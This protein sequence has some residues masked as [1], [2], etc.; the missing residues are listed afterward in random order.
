[1]AVTI[2][3]V[4]LLALV[5]YLDKLAFGSTSDDAPQETPV[6]LV[7]F[8]EIGKSLAWNRAADERKRAVID[9]L[10]RTNDNWGR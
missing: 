4:L 2:A 6:E 3:A 7:K 10:R 5:Y 9:E 1:M 8:E